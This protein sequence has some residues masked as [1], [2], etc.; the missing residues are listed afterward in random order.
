MFVRTGWRAALAAEMVSLWICIKVFLFVFRSVGTGLP[1]VDEGTAAAGEDIAAAD[2]LVDCEAV[3]G[4]DVMR[5][6]SVV[7]ALGSW[8]EAMALDRRSKG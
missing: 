6:M 4:S 1:R 7:P 8:L 3:P 2:V 5:S